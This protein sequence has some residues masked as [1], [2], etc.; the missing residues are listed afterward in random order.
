QSAPDFKM[1]KSLV[2]AGYGVGAGL[3]ALGIG[4]LIWEVARKP[5]EVRD[6]DLIGSR[7]PSI[8]FMPAFGPDSVGFGA[9]AA[10]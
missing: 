6:Q 4:M 1:Y 10:F 3:A 7:K 2:Y 5:A 9:V 8:R